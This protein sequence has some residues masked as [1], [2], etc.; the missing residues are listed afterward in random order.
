MKNDPTPSCLIISLMIVIP[1]TCELKLA[2]WIR[3]LTTS[4]GAATVMEATAPPMDATK[5]IISFLNGN[6]GLGTHSVPK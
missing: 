3:V 4:S 5:S 1:P 2:F 6:S